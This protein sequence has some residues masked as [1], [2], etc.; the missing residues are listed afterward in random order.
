MILILTEDYDSENKEV[1]NLLDYI[2]EFNNEIE[3]IKHPSKHSY[4]ELE[5]QIENA[6]ICIQVIANSLSDST[7]MNHCLHYAC[8]LQKYRMEDIPKVFGLQVSGMKL[9]NCSIHLEKEISILDLNAIKE[10]INDSC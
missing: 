2:Q 5:N 9:P 8:I 3:I 10:L 1:K 4:R 6:E 7:W